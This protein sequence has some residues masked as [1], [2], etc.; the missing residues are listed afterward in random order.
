MP[1]LALDLRFLRYAIAVAEHGSFRRAAVYL[2]VSQSVVSRR[3]Q[4]LERRLG[5]ALFIRHPS[6][7]RIT[8][9]GLR[10]IEEARTGVEHLRV[11]IS[12]L[13][14]RET[15]N[16]GSLRIG[17]STSIAGGLIPKLLMQLRLQFP[18]IDIR[19][20][21]DWSQSNTAAVLSGKLDAA[22]IPGAPPASGCECKILWHEP[23][24]VAVPEG[25]T[26]ASKKY[27]NW[28]DIRAEG[29][30]V[31]DAGSGQDINDYLIRT[32]STTGFRPK[33][34]V[35]RVGRE[36]LLSLVSLGFGLTLATGSALGIK[37]PGVIFLPAG[38]V[39]EKVGTSVVW[40][41]GNPNPCLKSLVT[42]STKL[43]K[44]AAFLDW[45]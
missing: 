24:F 7:A 12:G 44:S 21:E 3:V 16:G 4:L 41:A 36:G 11:A 23:I 37:Y 10:F 25:H 27:V 34:D 18:G 29:F 5:V 15:R 40:L 30:V 14:T 45:R 1:D 32:L 26:L 35:H 22:F 8:R 13:Q 9:A 38:D 33:V 20:E 17:I 42:I 43:S 31:P 39:H 19:L 28:E 2:D 6:G